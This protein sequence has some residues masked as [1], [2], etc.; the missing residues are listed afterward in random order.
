M[1]YLL[2]LAILL[3][4][5]VAALFVYRRLTAG[6][7][8]VLPRPVKLTV[9]AG[10][11]PLLPGG[12]TNS[13]S[14]VL[15]AQQRAGTRSS[16]VAGGDFEIRPDGDK[17]TGSPTVVTKDPTHV[18]SSCTGAAGCPSPAG[19]PPP[20]RVHLADGYYRWQVRLHNKDGVS[21]WVV[22]PGVVRIDTQPPAVPEILSSTDP[23]PAKTYH[24]STM[25]FQ[26]HDSDVGSGIAGYSYRLDAD[27][28]G[29]ARTE[30]RTPNTAVK[31]IGLDTGTWYFHVRAL[32]LAG[33]WGPTATFPVHIDVTPP[34]LANVR[35]NLFQFD[36]QFDALRVS[37]AVT[38]PATTVRLGV[39]RQ[40]DNALMRLYT[41]SHL[42]KNQE[43]AVTWDGKDASGRSV[44]PGSYEIYI[45]AID[46]YG[47]SSLSGWNDFVVD[48]RRILVS[49]SQQKLYAYDG[50]RLILTSLVTTG[51]RALP[52]PTGTYHIMAKFHPFTFISPWPK[53]SPFYYKPSKVQYA[54]LF[55]EGGYFIHDA[56]WRSAFGPGTNSQLGTPGTN[57]TGTHGCV[58]TPPGVAQQLYYWTQIGT[59]VQVVA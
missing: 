21:P 15:T 57:Y 51:N 33:N 32:D 54:M 10:S 42:P 17:F 29:A 12:W 47:H 43:T 9:T 59:I 36:P 2:A 41:L 4:G 45:R 37:F 26:W 58:N 44:N 3:A 39:Y 16:V 38:R 14:L 46:R 48:Y 56:P 49:L 52:T 31:L 53:S 20:A 34:G 40:G 27:P 30:L 24:S 23:N 1:R 28:N 35:F 7:A 6:P 8:V 11:V 55:R 13:S 50:S 25:R 19:D 5:A 22:Y 18:A